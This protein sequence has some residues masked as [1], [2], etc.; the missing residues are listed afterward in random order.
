V[1]SDARAG[2]SRQHSA[3]E[4]TAPAEEAAAADAVAA[5]VVD[6]FYRRMLSAPD[7]ARQRAQVA[8]TIAG[9]V[10]AAL[11]AAGAVAD[12]GAKP[13]WFQVLGAVALVAWLV[14]AGLFVWAVA[15]P[16]SAEAPEKIKGRAEFVQFA[17]D[18]HATEQFHIDRRQAMALSAGT[19]AAG[20][21]VIAIAL[22]LLRG[23][24]RGHA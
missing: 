14:T 11:V 23:R 7:L 22:V 9:A 24:R 16:Y 10:A 2:G 18:D 3:A 12:L 21:T 13:W 5:A 15:L 6:A 17:L 4:E 20:L 1:T 8:Y 19:V